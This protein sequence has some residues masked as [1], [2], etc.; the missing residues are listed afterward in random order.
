MDSTNSGATSLESLQLC[1]RLAAAPNHEAYKVTL[2]LGEI[3]LVVEAIDRDLR[4]AIHGA[5]H[6][7][8][9]RLRQR[10]YVVTSAEIVRALEEAIAQSDL[11]LRPSVQG[12]QGARDLN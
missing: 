6:R 11:G 3:D 9:S 7:C 5:A 8:A 1:L 12:V 2:E 4:G 10:G